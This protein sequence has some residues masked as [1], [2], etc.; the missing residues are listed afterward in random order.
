MRLAREPQ[1]L[2]IV[3]AVAEGR[4]AALIHAYTEVGK[5]VEHS[6]DARWRRR[7]VRAY[8]MRERA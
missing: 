8:R 6:L 5:V 7:I 1:H 4:P 2:A 3:S